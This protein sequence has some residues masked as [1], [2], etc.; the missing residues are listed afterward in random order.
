MKVNGCDLIF[1]I[2]HRYILMIWNK[3]RFHIFKFI[4]GT[5]FFRCSNLVQ[6]RQSDFFIS[7]TCIYWFQIFEFSSRPFLKVNGLK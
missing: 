3:A 6:E 5:V 7:N 1:F 4:M 2:S